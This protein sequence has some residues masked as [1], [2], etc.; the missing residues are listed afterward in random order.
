MATQA[1][2]ELK[3]PIYVTSQP[4]LFCATQ[5]TTQVIELRSFKPSSAGPLGNP[6]LC[7]IVLPEDNPAAIEAAMKTAKVASSIFYIGTRASNEV[8]E[9]ARSNNY[10]VYEISL[11]SSGKFYPVPT[12]GSQGSYI[13]IFCLNRNL[14]NNLQEES[15]DKQPLIHL[16]TSLAEGNI[17]PAPSSHHHHFTNQSLSPINKWTWKKEGTNGLIFLVIGLVT[18]Y[19]FM[20]VLPKAVR[21]AA[22]VGFGA[23]IFFKKS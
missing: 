15:P 21:A 7:F 1:F 16:I 8:R 18:A 3:Q 23:L 5:K 6:C 10:K 4:N 22:S 13:R 9:Q 17:T 2:C 19:L 14:L 11:G 12:K 20:R